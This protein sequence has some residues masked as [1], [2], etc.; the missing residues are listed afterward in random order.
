MN[1]PLPDDAPEDEAT[2]T[3]FDSILIEFDG[4]W[5]TTVRPRPPHIPPY[6]PEGRMLPPPTEPPSGRDRC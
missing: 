3:S 4:P 1:T 5:D 6:M 2:P